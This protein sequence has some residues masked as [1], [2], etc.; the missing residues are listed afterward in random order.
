MRCIKTLDLQIGNPNCATRILITIFGGESFA[1]WWILLGLGPWRMVK[2]VVNLFK[3]ENKSKKQIADSSQQISPHTQTTYLLR[4]FAWNF[5]G[6]TSPA[7]I[8]QQNLA[9]Y[10]HVTKNILPLWAL[11]QTCM[12]VGMN[13]ATNEQQ[14]NLEKNHSTSFC[15][16]FGTPKSSI[17]I[18]F[19][20][21]KPSN[22]GVAPFMEPS[23]VPTVRSQAIPIWRIPWGQPIKWMVYK[24]KSIYKWRI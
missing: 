10:L 23:M 20:C 17:F 4:N 21:Y 24:G 15:R 5:A 19:F 16:K 3:E 9:S 22:P 11:T 13:L 14:L 2:F 6:K 7:K 1:T 8:C 12:F 18:S